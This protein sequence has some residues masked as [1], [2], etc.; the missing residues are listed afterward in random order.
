MGTLGDTTSPANTDFLEAAAQLI[1]TSQFPI[2]G[3][4]P[5]T[6]IQ[7]TANSLRNVA[8]LLDQDPE[9]ARTLGLNAQGIA[10]LHG[11]AGVLAKFSND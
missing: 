10:Y 5:A 3:T 1:E 7:H 9:Y 2:G 6:L 8:D 11:A 4:D